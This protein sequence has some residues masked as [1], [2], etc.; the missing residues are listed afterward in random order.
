VL[1]APSWRRWGHVAK[2]SKV[3][4]DPLLFTMLEHVAA[5]RY[6]T[7]E[8]TIAE[9]VRLFIRHVRN[10]EKRWQRLPIEPCDGTLGGWNEPERPRF[11]ERDALTPARRRRDP[12][13]ASPA[14]SRAKRG[15]RRATK[16]AKP[17]ARKRA[18]QT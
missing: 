5:R 15:P 3:Q 13:R 7:T 12:L 1:C 8:R 10:D 18:R 4:L 16:P 11:L 6:W 17:T 9:A 14:T 2:A